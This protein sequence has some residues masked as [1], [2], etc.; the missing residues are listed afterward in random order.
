M[1]HSI[2]VPTSAFGLNR[3]ADHT[4]S[5]DICVTGLHSLSGKIF[6]SMSRLISVGIFELCFGYETQSNPPDFTRWM[7]MGV[8]FSTSALSRTN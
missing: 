3:S 7:A 8:S 4:S 1:F 2:Q 5:M 6:Q